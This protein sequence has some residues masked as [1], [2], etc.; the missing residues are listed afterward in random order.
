M[1]TIFI[2]LLKNKYDL[3]ETEQSLLLKTV[4]QLKKEDRRYYFKHIK[5]REKIFKQHLRNYYTSLDE[6]MQRQWIDGVAQSMLGRGGEPNIM[7]SLVMNAIGRLSV[8][9]HMRL[10]AENDGIKLNALTNFGGMGAVIMLVG[11]ITALV[12]YLFAK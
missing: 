9:N 5:P 7:D 1:A 10:K 8:Y 4:R 2:K 11:L 12:L 3:N 6:D